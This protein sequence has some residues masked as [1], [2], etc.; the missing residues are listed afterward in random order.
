VIAPAETKKILLRAADILEMGWCRGAYAVSGRP[1]L[2]L[3][4]VSLGTAQPG[5]DRFCLTGAIMKAVQE[6]EGEGAAG[7]L[8]LHPLANA[9]FDAVHAEIP[10]SA[11]TGWNDAM[12]PSGEVAAAMVREAA[13]A[14]DR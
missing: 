2:G 4:Q 14:L 6:H 5:V 12:C 7:H 8:M 3:Y 9:A 10:G 13:R 11:M 1:G